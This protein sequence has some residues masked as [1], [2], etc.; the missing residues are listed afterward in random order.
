MIVID[1]KIYN[2]VIYADTVRWLDVFRFSCYPAFRGNIPFCC[3]K[4]EVRSTVIVDLMK[5][6]DDLLMELKSNTRNEVRRAIRDSYEIMQV[7]DISEF[8]SFYN[9]FAKEKGL[10]PITMGSLKKFPH[11]L[12]YKSTLDDV[13]MAMHANIVDEDNKIVRLL[14]SAS[15]RLSMGVDRKCVGIANRFLHY[16]EFIQFKKLGYV[17][18]DFAG[19]CEDEN[20]KELYHITQFKKSFGGKVQSAIFLYS[21]PF[22]IA[23]L[24]KNI[25]KRL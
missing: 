25:F 12:L 7:N 16:K 1:K 2:L 22:Y 17:L 21:I 23:L 18:Y 6:E 10:A 3:M 11:L 5:T 15:T 8:V 19:I 20:N 9:D 4:K 24:V 14:Y 13:V